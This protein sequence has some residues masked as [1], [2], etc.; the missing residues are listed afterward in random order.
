MKHLLLSVLFICTAGWAQKPVTKSPK[1]TSDWDVLDK[2]F[3]AFIKALETNDKV[4][5][6][7][8]SLPQVDC[9]ECPNA[10]E[11][12][13]KNN[14]VPAEVFYITVAKDFTVSP[15]Y[16]A[17]IKRG[18]AFNSMTLKDFKPGFLPK[19]YPKDLKIYE[20]WVPTYKPD[21]LS[22]GHKGTNH[23]FQFIKINGEFKFYG[24]TSQ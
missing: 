17:M 24:L 13:A 5:Y 2:T 18:Y 8:L 15:V 20:V 4:A 14:F 6:T 11:L 16:K 10:A 22:K 23:A 19:D 12:G 1:T 7:A 3:I 21:E 9:V